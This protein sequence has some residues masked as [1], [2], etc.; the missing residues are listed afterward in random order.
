MTEE[1]PEI[2]RIVRDVDYSLW[3]KKRARDKGYSSL[4]EDY[5]KGYEDCLNKIRNDIRE[6]IKKKGEDNEQIKV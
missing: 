4:G 2:E 1:Y 5:L 3:K 6:L